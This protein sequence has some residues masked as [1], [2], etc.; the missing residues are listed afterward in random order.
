MGSNPFFV[1]GIGHIHMASIQLLSVIFRKYENFRHDI[2]KELLFSLHQLP[3]AKN[4]KN[5]YRLSS[6]EYIHNF[7]VLVLQLIQSVVIVSYPIVI[8]IIDQKKQFRYLLKNEQ[9]KVKTKNLV[10][11]M[12]LLLNHALKKLKNGLY[13]F[14]KLFFINALQKLKK[15]IVENL[16][17][18]LMIFWLHFID[19]IGLLLNLCL[20]CLEVY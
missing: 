16:N 9:M 10:K 6:N 12:I 15:I 4:L 17:L 19:L 14:L 5:C 2:I 18:F 11:K 20:Q 7:T 1:D 8:D 3:P 13:F